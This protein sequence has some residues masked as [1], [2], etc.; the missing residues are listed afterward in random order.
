MK[1]ITVAK[2]RQISRQYPDVEKS[3]QRWIKIVEGCEAGHIVDLR[4]TFPTADAVGV[5]RMYTCFNIKGNSYRL[6]T[7]IFYDSQEVY[8]I[9]FLTHADYD[10]K[11]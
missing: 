6:I 7:H 4:K 1:V 5:E 11:Y 9:D 10:K 8:I 3:L 2:L